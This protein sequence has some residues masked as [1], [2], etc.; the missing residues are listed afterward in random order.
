MPRSS[1]GTGTIFKRG[2]VWYVS[3]WADGR[4]IQKSS[5]SQKRQDAVRLRDQLL[6]KKA[7]GEM[8]DIVSAKV[9]CGELLDDLL[10]YAD[11]NI[12]ASTARIWKLVIEASI[13][14]FFG[15][16]RAAKLTTEK[17]KEFRRKRSA[18][19]R[20]DATSNR[21]LSILRTALNR[22]RKCTPPKVLTIPYFPMVAET[23]VRQGFLNDEQ[24][25]RLRDEIADYL[26]PLFVTAYFTGVRLGELQAIQWHQVDWEQGFITLDSEHTKS[27]YA[28]AVPILDGDMRRWLTWSKQNAA[29]GDYIF[30]NG[31]APIKEFRRAWKN[32]CELAGVPDL[33]FHD[34]R[35]TAVRNMRRSGVPQVVRMRITGHRTDSM[36]RRYNIVDIEDIRSAKELMQQKT[37]P[38]K[39]GD[40]G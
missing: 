15:D 31:G 4:Q 8:G 39:D 34:L 12:K 2:D 37:K 35:R 29:G 27:G 23:H 6:G 9:T 32:A 30:H 33:K 11:S 3:F 19:G 24:Y 25:E 5:G 28:R 38:D 13:R 36:E 40:A 20:S 10:E 17:L 26:K 14:P 16:L 7:R 21:E 22:G 18:E 1:Y